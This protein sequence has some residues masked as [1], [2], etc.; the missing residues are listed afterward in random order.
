MPDTGELN[1]ASLCWLIPSGIAVY[2][3]YVVGFNLFWHP[4]AA[5]PGPPLAAIST[6]YK[7]YIDLVSKSSFV[8]TL[9]KLHAQYGT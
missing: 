7:A 4:L 9:E 2:W 1:I 3:V 5:F 6:L 8:H